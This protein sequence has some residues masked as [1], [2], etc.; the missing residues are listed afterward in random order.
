MKITQEPDL[1]VKQEKR[2]N[3]KRES[4]MRYHLPS[5]VQPTDGPETKEPGK[6]G[7]LSK[8]ERYLHIKKEK[9]QHNTKH[10]PHSL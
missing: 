4:I 1:L 7:E 2:R 5:V 8:Q 9:T 3:K 10:T 6:T